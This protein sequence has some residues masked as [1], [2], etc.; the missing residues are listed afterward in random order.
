MCYYFSLVYVL[1]I[2]KWYLCKWLIC[3]YYKYMG[4]S[5]LR[6]NTL[7]KYYS[8]GSDVSLIAVP[9]PELVSYFVFLQWK[10]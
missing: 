10:S 2:Y 8:E 1:D 5:E 6:Q 7:F 4:W 9:V 3:I